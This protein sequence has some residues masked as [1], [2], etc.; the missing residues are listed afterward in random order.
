[1]IVKFIILVLIYK[2]NN[3]HNN[4]DNAIDNKLN[5]LGPYLVA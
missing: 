5:G 2:K 4:S 3:N 1:M